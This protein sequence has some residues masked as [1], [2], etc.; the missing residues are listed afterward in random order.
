VSA[1]DLSH[2]GQRYGDRAFLDAPRLGELA[3]SDRELL[4]VACRADADALFQLVARRNDAD[5]MYGLPALY[6]L[7]EV[8][9][10]KRGELLK[11]DQA[12]ELDGTACS[13]FAS[14]AFYEK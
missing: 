14:L 3:A 11:Y 6:T 1:G 9:R 10:P 13:S 5:R 12:G 4:E 7:L 8:A 2:V